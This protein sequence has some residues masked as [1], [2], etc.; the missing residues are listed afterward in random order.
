VD[1]QAVRWS[2][3][4]S[5]KQYLRASLLVLLATG[6]TGTAFATNDTTFDTGPELGRR[7]LQNVVRVRSPE[8]GGEHGFGVVI[9]AQGGDV[10]IATARHVVVRSADAARAR[11]EVV[12]C[13]GDGG[14]A[15]GR[16]AE[17]VEGFDAGGMDVALLKVARPSGYEPLVR[18]LAA[19][20]SV[21]LRQETWVL[22]QDDQCGVVPR[23]GAVA[24]LRDARQ[25]L[26]IEFPGVRGG[27]SGGPAI[28]GYGV[29]GIVTDADDL[30]FTVLGIAGI[31][32]R[33]QASR[34]R[35]AV[36]WQLVDARNIPPS[37]PRSA[38]VDLGETLNQYLFA[39]NNLQRLLLQPSIPR[40][41]F[42]A[43][44][45]D[46]N[47][48]MNRFRD[49]RTRH[50]GTLQRH[51]P[52]PVLERWLVLRETLWQVHQTF[53]DLNR[54]DSQTIFDQQKAPP[55]VKERMHA[56]DPQLVQLQA[57]I[58]GFLRSLEQRS[59]R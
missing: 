58:N 31:Q 19:D 27:T 52:A 21:E 50:D 42:V 37:D 35:S 6:A 4:V 54:A 16:V 44:A 32:A 45:N 39:V 23:S 47:A 25:N 57:D 15:A 10:F 30:T 14:P 24:S 53:W 36:P 12:F 18:A 17:L 5:A 28:S 59:T 46:Y 48:A 43:F 26:R 51:W 49:A 33:W 8:A 3:V 7:L 34:A 55:A 9:G 40:Q 2:T 11:I 56:L 20:E 1:S 41:R 13:A 29:L 38:E 22:G